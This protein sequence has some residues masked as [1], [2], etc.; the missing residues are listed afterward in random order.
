MKPDR[1]LPVQAE[2]HAD[3]D[4]LVS[5]EP[6]RAYDYY[7]ILAQTDAPER[8]L[9]IPYAKAAAELAPTLGVPALEA[10]YLEFALHAPEAPEAD[11]ATFA[12]A[13]AAPA[14]LLDLYRHEPLA[15]LLRAPPAPIRHLGARPGA[16]GDD[17]P[18]EREPRHRPA[19]PAQHCLRWEK[20]CASNGTA[21]LS[22]GTR[23]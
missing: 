7:P 17:P 2:P 22:A 13:L 23:R 6:G 9:R 21:A 15:P 19:G 5:L 8:W 18:S 3:A 20:D 16:R 11:V 14:F 12:A 10:L 1:A 4:V